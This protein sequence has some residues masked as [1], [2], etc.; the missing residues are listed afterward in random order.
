MEKSEMKRICAEKFPKSPALSG[1]GRREPVSCFRG[2]AKLEF[3]VM[4]R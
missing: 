2:C 1:A 3:S 4:R